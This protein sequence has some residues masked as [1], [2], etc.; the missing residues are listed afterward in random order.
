MKLFLTLVILSGA[1][2]PAAGLQSLT[3]DEASWMAKDGRQVELAF[4]HSVSRA[5]AD[6]Y[7]NTGAAEITYGLFDRV[8]LL[9]S[10]PWQGWNSRGISD[11]GIGG[12]ALEAKFSSGRRYGWDLALKPGFSLPA[13]DEASGFGAGKGGVWTYGIASRVA[14]AWGGY[15][16]AAYFYNRNSI[17][18]D[19]HLLT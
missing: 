1:C 3:G 18:E 12:V 17:G 16:N 10:A 5:G 2:L 14:G 6:V 15:L 8:D 7:S 11:S 19:E 13:G 9:L 4:D